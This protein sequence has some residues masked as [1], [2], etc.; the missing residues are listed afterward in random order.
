MN[1]YFQLV[2]NEVGTSLYIFPP[3]DGGNVIDINEVTNYLQRK[4][5]VF[6]ITAINVAIRNAKENT[7]INL[8]NQKLLP[9]PE[10]IEVKVTSDTM[11]AIA[12]FY[13]PSLGGATKGKAE[14]INL[15]KQQKVIA[16]IEEEAIDN[17]IK[18]REYCTD[19]VVAKGKMPR[20]G[21]DAT[22]EY[23]FNTD[24]KVRPTLKNDGSVDFFNLNTINHCR[25]GEVLANLNK[26]DVGE[27]GMG[28]LGNIIRPR[29]VKRCKLQYSNHIEISEDRTVIT[30]Q[31]N[32]HVCLVNGK[33]FVSDVYQVE[34][35]DNATGNIEY[36]GSVLVTANVCSNFSV[37]AHGDVEVRGVVEGAYIEADGNIVIARGM[38]GMSRGKL[39]AGGNVVAKFIENATVE[40]GGYVETEAILHST[41]MARTEVNVLSHKGFITGGKVIAT[42][43]I[44]VKNLG[45]PMGA[46]TIVEIGLDPALKE[47]YNGLQKEVVTIHKTLQ[48]IEPIISATR[49]KLAKGERLAPDRLKYVQTLMLANKQKNERLKECNKE[50]QDLQELLQ[51]NQNA[52]VTVSG[53]VYGGTKI[54]ISDS[55]LTVKDTVKY[56][57]FIRDQGEIKMSNL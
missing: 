37:I 11:Q 8:S 52:C 16:G 39:K 30:S 48:Q 46:D 38:N 3:T 28:V 42:N 32:G 36:E 25:K 55:A 19:I 10:M 6:D 44:N 24:L 53:E 20:H 12:R 56:C 5:I 18:H 49:Q 57:R 51:S 17:F 54:V 13:P 34:N 21:K 29:E 7:L 26:E 2:L 31:V 40:A 41:V 35:V 43:S 50:I 45:S 23:F 33:V 22:I 15:L 27:N 4:K 1:G 14:I 9:E 47:K